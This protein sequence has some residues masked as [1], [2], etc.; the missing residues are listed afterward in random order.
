MTE[1]ADEMMI[2]T[3]YGRRRRG[4]MKTR[5]QLGQGGIFNRARSLAWLRGIAFTMDL[6]WLRRPGPSLRLQSEST[7]VY[8]LLIHIV[9]KII[10]VEGRN[11]SHLLL[12]F[13]AHE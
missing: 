2:N 13:I 7:R 1:D 10:N 6:V 8:S 12:C 5:N 9:G 11:I 3:K 4:G